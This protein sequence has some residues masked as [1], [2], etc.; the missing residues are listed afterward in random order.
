M[1]SIS[2]KEIVGVEA[3]LIDLRDNGKAARNYWVYALVL[4]TMLPTLLHAIIW[5]ISLISF[6]LPHNYKET[7]LA[8]FDAGDPVSKHN[9]QVKLTVITQPHIRVFRVL[10]SGYCGQK[11][12]K[13]GFSGEFCGIDHGSDGAI[14]FSRPH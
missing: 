11:G 14:A 9:I 10:N 12:L 13:R 1:D 3:A 8:Q 7:M 2:G 4:S 6:S 5:V